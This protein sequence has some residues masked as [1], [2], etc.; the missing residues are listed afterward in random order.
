MFTP[1]LLDQNHFLVT[2]GG[3]G[4]GLAMTSRFLELGASVSI[5]GRR[6]EKLQ[7][8]QESLGTL[9]EKLDYVVCDVRDYDAVGKMLGQIFESHP[10]FNRLLNN[11]AGNF[12]SASEDL[13]PNGFKTVVDIV[14]HGTFN[15]TQ[16][17][18]KRLIEMGKEAAVLNIVTTYAQTDPPLY[19]PSLAPNQECTHLRNRLHSSGQHMGFV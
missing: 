13:T 2:G 7:A 18:G 17:F 4:L 8:A 19:C 9:G 11:A 6:E 10:N 3:S 14:L 15:C 12:Y 5:C 1:D 16:Q